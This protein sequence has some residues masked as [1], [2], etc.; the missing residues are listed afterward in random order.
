MTD[1]KVY[2]I[3]IIAVSDYKPINAENKVDVLKRLFK[4]LHYAEKREQE[5]ES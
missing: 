3:A 4:D 5:L 2:K 1:A